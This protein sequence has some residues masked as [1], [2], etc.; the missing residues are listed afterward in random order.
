MTMGQAKD[1]GTQEERRQQRMAKMLDEAE[2]LIA[3]SSDAKGIQFQ[4]LPR[5]ETPNQT[6]EAVILAAFINHNFGN[7]MQTAMAAYRQHEAGG[8]EK[9]GMIKQRPV[10]SLTKPDG[11]LAKDAPR[12]VGADGERLT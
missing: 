8:S 11:A 9:T 2:V 1:R 12:L 7:L 6:S 10:L 4:I 3:L 5:D